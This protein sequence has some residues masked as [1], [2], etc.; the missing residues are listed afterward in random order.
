[1]LAQEH[2]SSVLCPSLFLHSSHCSLGA[3]AR[4]SQAPIVKRENTPLLSFEMDFQGNVIC[5]S[6]FNIAI[7]RKDKM[8]K[9]SWKVDLAVK[10]F[11]GAILESYNILGCNAWSLIIW[12]KT[13]LFCSL[14]PQGCTK[15]QE[16]QI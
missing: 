14:N 13:P 8:N 2:V 11:W 4:P 3:F 10:N 6:V 12:R 5:A 7:F 15:F 1:M 16:A 9:L